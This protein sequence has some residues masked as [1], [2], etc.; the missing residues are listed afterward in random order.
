M[1]LEDGADEHAHPHPH[2]C[3]H[4]KI[5]MNNAALYR[6]TWCGNPSAVLRKCG[7]CGKTR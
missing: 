7:G 3:S 5:S 4:P 6:C 2:A 1:K